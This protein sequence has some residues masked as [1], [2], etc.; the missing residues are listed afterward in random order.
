MYLLPCFGDQGYMHMSKLIHGQ[1][2]IHPHGPLHVAAWI[3]N[4]LV[5]SESQEFL[6]VAGLSQ[7]L[8]S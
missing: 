3:S 5:V 7:D 2:R 8:K 6:Q 1:M 4:S